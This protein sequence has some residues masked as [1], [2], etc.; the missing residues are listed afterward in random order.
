MKSAGWTLMET[1]VAV[2]L[3][4]ALTGIAVS[5][6]PRMSRAPD[7]EQL[8]TRVG[9]ML[10]AAHTQAVGEER[11]VSVTGAGE[12][13]TLSASEE[14]EAERFGQA[15]LSGTVVISAGGSST[16]ALTVQGLGGSCRKL[17]LSEIGNVIA[18]SC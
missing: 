13:L 7:A 15:Q 14:S 11:Q 6:L 3:L 10:Q 5:Q 17:S 12:G 16:G 8:Q 18:G 9:A 4:V 2:A 1:M